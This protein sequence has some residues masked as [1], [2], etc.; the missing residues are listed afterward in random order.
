MARLAKCVE[1]DEKDSE[2]RKVEVKRCRER[3]LEKRKELTTFA[4]TIND[5]VSFQLS[6]FKDTWYL[7]IYLF[8]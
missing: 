3:I 2:S 6:L 5:C 4:Q 1:A 7:F 8:I